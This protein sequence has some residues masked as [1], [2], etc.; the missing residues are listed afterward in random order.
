M[1]KIFVFQSIQ[2]LADTDEE[3]KKA[4]GYTFED[5][6]LECEFEGSHCSREYVSSTSQLLRSVFILIAN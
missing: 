2:I 3:V 1:T 6:V 4:M 5:I